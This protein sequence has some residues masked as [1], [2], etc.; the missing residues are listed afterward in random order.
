MR[1]TFV[2]E[3]GIRM[4]VDSW[5]APED[6]RIDSISRNC[7]VDFEGLWLFARPDREIWTMAVREC[8][9]RNAS[10]RYSAQKVLG[11]R[12][13]GGVEQ[14][15]WFACLVVVSACFS[16]TAEDVFTYA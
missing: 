15:S 9:G 10:S 11:S 12:F 7:C 4:I 1:L 5:L 13:F 3:D 2:F 14:R 16:S 8:T 6:R